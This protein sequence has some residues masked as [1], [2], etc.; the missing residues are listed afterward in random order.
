MAEYYNQSFRYVQAAMIDR[1]L[2]NREYHVRKQEMRWVHEVLD[3]CILME[4]VNAKETCN[5]L[6]RQYLKMLRTHKSFGL[7]ELEHLKYHVPPPGTPD[8]RTERIQ[9]NKY[10]TR[11]HDL[12]YRI[13][14][15]QA[16][17]EKA[18]KLKEMMDARL[19]G[20]P[21]AE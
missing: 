14:K 12:Q 9:V 11:E 6:V 21:E 20:E 15:A 19:R 17:E 13:L 7:H 4:G 1:E 8:L 5:H 16:E 18:K 3:L 10:L 2:F